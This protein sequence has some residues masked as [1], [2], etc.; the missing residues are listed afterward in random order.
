MKARQTF[1]FKIKVLLEF[2]VAYSPWPTSPY[3]DSF[4]D[5]YI[6]GRAYEYHYSFVRNKT[7]HTTDTEERHADTE[8]ISQNF[9]GVHVYLD[10]NMMMEYEMI[11]K[12]SFPAFLSQVGGAL[13][14]WAGITVVVVIELIE[15]C[16][17]ILADCK[18][19]GPDEV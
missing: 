12:V 10:Q 11:A 18:K 8:H 16:F 7:L 6:A 3:H 2:Q 1:E 17:R 5:D 19:P 15:M 4:Y 14:F 9:L 13:N